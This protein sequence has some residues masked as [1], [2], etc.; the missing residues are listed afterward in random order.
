MP[1]F[2]LAAPITFGLF[3][4]MCIDYYYDYCYLVIE[5]IWAHMSIHT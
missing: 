3:Q 5:V 4:L 1:P 2:G